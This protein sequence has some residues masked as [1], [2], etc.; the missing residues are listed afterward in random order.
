MMAGFS[1]GAISFKGD[2]RLFDAIFKPRSRL[3]TYQSTL[4]SALKRWLKGRDAE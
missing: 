3:N 2:T 4:G 1:A